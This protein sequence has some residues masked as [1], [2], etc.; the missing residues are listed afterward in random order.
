MGTRCSK[1]ARAGQGRAGVGMEGF[2]FHRVVHQGLPGGVR[3][4]GLG[5]IALLQV[6]CLGE[7]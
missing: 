5:I 1:P 2:C 4:F 3:R 7:K 6:L